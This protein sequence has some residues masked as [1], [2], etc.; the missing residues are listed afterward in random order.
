[1][2]KRMVN[3]AIIELTI[4][5]IGPLLI[6]ASDQGA[7]PTK[8]DMEFVETYHEGD[9][10]VYLPGSSLKGAIRA[11]CERIVRTLGGNVTACDPLKTT[12]SCRNLDEEN[13]ATLYKN[14]CTV[15]QIFGSTDISAHARI[16]DAYPINPKDIRREER[17]GVA[18]DRVYGS[19][20]HGP[21]N[22]EVITAGAFKTTIRV[23][24]FT[25]VQLAL[26]ALA[27][28]DF[29]EQRVGIGF[30]KSRGLGQVNMKVNRVA[31]HYPTAV[32]EDNQVRPIGNQTDPFSDN[33]VIG[34]GQLVND[35][36]VYGFP[37]P[38]SINVNVRA[39][40]DDY[41]FGATLSFEESNDITALWRE[42]VGSWR[43]M[44]E[45]EQ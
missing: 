22:F 2:H 43:N 29:D 44:I 13:G 7:D 16:A 33:A 34:A 40:P 23:K 30:A 24:N 20:A 9:R 6:K 11:H 15:C 38:D 12:S 28:R 21:F 27:I 45:G 5:P 37:N 41:G 4:S 19:V 25:T 42:C 36:E 26:I 18:I 8:P 14:T 1:M 17:N 3:Q 32:V 39:Q 31:I 35:A 10:S